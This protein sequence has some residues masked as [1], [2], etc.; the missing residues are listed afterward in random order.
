MTIREKI[1]RELNQL[2]EELLAEIYRY[3]QTVKPVEPSTER[4]LSTFKL[5]GA[6]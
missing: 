2:P 6:V 5:K 4:K 1:F 3:I